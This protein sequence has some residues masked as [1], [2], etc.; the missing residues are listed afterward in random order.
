[1]LWCSCDGVAFAHTFAH[2]FSLHVLYCAQGHSL[3]MRET[4]H[5]MHGMKMA[6][7]N[8]YG[9]RYDGW[10]SQDHF[11]GGST[12]VDGEG[13]VQMPFDDVYNDTFNGL[14][15][16]SHFPEGSLVA[17]DGPYRPPP[18]KL[19]TARSRRMEPPPRQR[20]LGRDLGRVANLTNTI[21]RVDFHQGRDLLHWPEAMPA[22]YSAGPRSPLSLK[23]LYLAGGLEP[24]TAPRQAP[25]RGTDAPSPMAGS[26]NQLLFQL[27]TAAA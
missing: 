11:K 12:D 7:D 13:P 16:K 8:V 24:T 14:R 17:E 6:F 19:T 22:G 4:P 27:P 18:R 1:M 25:P 9:S 23:S 3:A 10:S 5:E 2:A 26:A 20:F 21:G 15:S